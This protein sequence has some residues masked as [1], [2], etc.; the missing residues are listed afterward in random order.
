MQVSFRKLQS[1]GSIKPVGPLRTQKCTQQRVVSVKT[2]AKE[3]MEAVEMDDEKAE[4]SK[5]L[6]KPYKYG[7]KSTIEQ[8]STLKNVPEILLLWFRP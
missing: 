3:A 5:M 6:N 2:A 1:L 4:I 7:F 8:V